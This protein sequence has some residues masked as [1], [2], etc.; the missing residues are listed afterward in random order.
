MPADDYKGFNAVMT[1]S[2]YVAQAGQ[3]RLPS[4][5]VGMFFVF[6][7][8]VLRIGLW[9]SCLQGKNSTNWAMSEPRQVLS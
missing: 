2:G 4:A 6:I 8:A 1:F 9:A 5:G 3:Q 7:F